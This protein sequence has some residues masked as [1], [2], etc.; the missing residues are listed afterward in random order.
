MKKF[1][2]GLIIGALV[3]LPAGMNIGKGKPVLSN[4]FADKP[5]MQEIQDTARRAAD[6]AKRAAQQAGEDASRAEQRATEQVKQ[7]TSEMATKGREMIH[8]GTKPDVPAQPQEPRD[9]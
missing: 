3:G 9:Y 4:P 6:E 8:G 1:F 2:W 7:S 5:L